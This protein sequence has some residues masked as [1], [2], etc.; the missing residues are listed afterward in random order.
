MDESVILTLLKADLDIS[1]DKKN[2]YL[3][4]LIKASREFISQEGIVLTDSYGDGILVEM[5]AAYLYRKR[6]EANP[7]M[8]R[9]LRWALN[10]RLMGGEVT[11]NG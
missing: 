1:T 2:D 7:V 6:R 8:P 11:T 4:T 9:M 5:Y 3:I 10:C